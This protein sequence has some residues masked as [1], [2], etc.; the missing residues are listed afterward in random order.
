MTGGSS[1][2]SAVAL[3][4][5][6][7]GFS[8]GGDTGG[9]VRWPAALCGV[10]GFKTTGARWPDYFTQTAEDA[11][12]LEAALSGTRPRPVPALAQVRLGLPTEHFMEDLDVPPAT[13]VRATASTNAVYRFPSTSSGLP[14]R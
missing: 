5:G 3:A 8:V 4:A 10:V 12:C 9:S 14:G 2:G 11:A 13:P 7:C 6:L 1:H